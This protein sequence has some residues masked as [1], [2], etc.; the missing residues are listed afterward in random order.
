MKNI[1][2]LIIWFPVVLFSQERISGTIFE[3]HPENDALVLAGANVYW[4]NTSVGAVTD[5]DGEFT[6]AYKP[7]YSKLVISYVGFKTDTLTVR[8]A[9]HITHRLK[10]VSDLNAVTVTS[11]KQATAKSYMQ[12]QNVFT[13]SSDE[14]LKAACCNLAES[15]ETN[16]SIDVNFADAISGTR[17]IKM[18]GLTSPYILI[19]TENIPSIRGASQAFGLSFIPGTWVES[20]QITKGAGSV[21]NGYESIAGQ[22]NAELV[23]PT[24]DDNVF[25]NVFG[26]IAGRFEL[27]THINTKVSDKWSTGLYLHGNTH[28]EKHDVNDDNFLDMPLYNQINLMN[29]WQYTNL[30]KGFVSFINVKFLNDEKQ[31]GELDF[32]PKTDKLTQNAWGSEIDTKRYEISSKIGYVN[33]EIPYQSL[34]VQ[35]AFSRHI[36]ES[37]FGLNQ[38][39]I[40]HNS[41]YASATYNSIIS[42]SRHKIKTGASY[43]YDDYEELVNTTDYE[44]TEYSVGGFF[45][46]NFDNLDKLNVTAGLRLDYHNL[47]GA[48]ITPRFHARYT[49]WEKSAIRASFGRGKRSAN[50]FTENQQMFATSRQINILS[51]GGDIY[52]LDPEIA[53]NYGLSYLQGF[54]LFGRKADITLDYYKTDFTNQVVVDY[55]N[56]LE[57]NFYNLE[58]KSYASSFQAEV[59]YNVFESFDLRL[60]YKFYDVK[61]DYQSGTLEKPLVPKNRFFA[62]ASYET[63]K[64]GEIIPHWRFDATFNWLSQQ[65]LASTTLN[66]V[67][68]QLDEYTP[69]VGTLNAQITRVFSPKFEVYLGGENMTNVRQNNPVLSA[70]NP[71]SGYFD[72]TFV[73]GP[74]FGANYYM[75]L[76]FRIN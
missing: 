32:N 51:S 30:E 48:F 54:N 22:I 63:R 59:N 73:Y 49:P 5:M 72:S 74:I 40:T 38:Y 50:I 20:I 6:L 2:Y 44:R 66:P 43:T 61:T 57:V 3:A 45:E 41:L 8:S 31:M 34:G 12:S 75:G 64:H 28:N 21:V 71:F 42:D 76:R 67:A 11:R 52:G 68:Y 4:L 29:R 60:A 62:N 70:D 1:I 17:Q 9:K 53:W 69:T 10:P 18:L 65:R 25:L 27:N 56:P 46:Y 39:E 36:Q 33:P 37:Y 16:P 47:L 14:L 15:F 24:T 23:K 19:A 58:G 26:N 35:T 13:V 7:E 55:E